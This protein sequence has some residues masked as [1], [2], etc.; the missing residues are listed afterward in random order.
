VRMFAVL[1]AMVGLFYNTIVIARFVSLYGV[2]L[3]DDRRRDS[4]P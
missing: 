2:K 3:R 4:E 1:E